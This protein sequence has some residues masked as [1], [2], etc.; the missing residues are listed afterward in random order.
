ATGGASPSGLR[1]HSGGRGFEDRPPGGPGSGDDGLTA[2]PSLAMRRTHPGWCHCPT[3]L[4]GHDAA[5]FRR[6]QGNGN[7]R[8]VGLILTLLLLSQ[9]PGNAAP[10]ATSCARTC[11]VATKRCTNRPGGPPRIRRRCARVLRALLA[12][13]ARGVVTA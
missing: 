1:N 12:C 13:G 6:W 2:G 3:V 5:S 8:I 11:R 4:D 7:V 9:A 10:N